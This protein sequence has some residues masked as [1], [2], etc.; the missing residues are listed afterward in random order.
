MYDWIP[1][2]FD[3]W[4]RWDDMSYDTYHCIANDAEMATFQVFK[5][6]V[7]CVNRAYE[8]SDL[9][10]AMRHGSQINGMNLVE[11]KSCK[12]DEDDSAPDISGLI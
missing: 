8:R 3:F 5:E 12:T 9:L 6:G 7:G 10:E 11:L 4:Y 1:R 2:E